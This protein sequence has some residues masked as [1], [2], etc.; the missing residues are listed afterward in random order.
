MKATINFTVP[1]ETVAAKGILLLI[2][3]LVFEIVVCYTHRQLPPAEL[4]LPFSYAPSTLTHFK[5]NMKEFSES[6]SA[7]ELEH[8][9]ARFREKSPSAV[10]STLQYSVLPGLSGLVQQKRDSVDGD[11]KHCKAPEA[12][13][14]TENEASLFFF[15][16]LPGFVQIGSW[17]H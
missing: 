15:Y 12:L 17:D 10:I 1:P 16:S 5:A 13:K 9:S 3:C 7:A 2:T 6:F 4:G 14:T 8:S 11:I